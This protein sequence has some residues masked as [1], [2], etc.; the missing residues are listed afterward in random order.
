[1]LVAAGNPAIGSA[2][3]SVGVSSAHSLISAAAVVAVMVAVASSHPGRRADGLMCGE[4]SREQSVA[5]CG[6]HPALCLPLAFFLISVLHYSLL[7]H[8]ASVP[9][10]RSCPG[11]CQSA[12]WRGLGRSSAQARLTVK[13][14]RSRFSAQR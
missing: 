3:C 10:W 7:S 13:S 4:M 9:P 14:A 8:H 6:L 12:G 5:A 1:M 11:G 2:S